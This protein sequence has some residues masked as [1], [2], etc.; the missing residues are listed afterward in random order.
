MDRRI[1]IT[2]SEGLIGSA[3]RASLEACGREIVG[4][5][6]RG[7]GNDDGDVRDPRRVR[8]AIADCR[9]V[10]HL[11]TVSRVIWGERDPEDCWNTNV[12]GVCNVIE[13]AYE[14][15]LRPWIIF[16]SSR[17]VYGQPHCLPATEDSFET[18]GSTGGLPRFS[19]AS[20]P[21]SCT[22]DT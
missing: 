7:A 15:A 5:D 12:R 1:L 17:E 10:V 3:L 19:I 14:Q 18:P 16:A 9:G 13:A 4:L 11:A 8:D 20:G 22:S 21:T 2:G 6:L